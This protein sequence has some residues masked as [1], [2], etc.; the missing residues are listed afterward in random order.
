[1]VWKR[2]ITALVLVLP[3]SLT[4]VAQNLS[5]AGKELDRRLER[6]RELYHNDMYIA[7]REEIGNILTQYPVS[8][9]VESELATC[10]II[11][12]IRLASPNLDALMDEYGEK[13]RYAPE[14]MGVLLM[15][16]GYY[17]DRGDYT[18][19]QK[20]LDEVEYPLLSRNDKTVYLFERSYCQLR[21]GR[22]AEARN[23]FDRIL[24][25]R[26]N[27]YTVASTYYRGYIAYVEKDFRKAVKLLSSI[28]H[29]GHFGRILRILHPGIQ[30]HAGGLRLCGR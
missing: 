14:Y 1:M 24:D 6:V 3:L 5:P 10:A 26:Q 22:L 13:Y 11:C 7:A 23:G 19:A 21:T 4:A 2:L 29:D 25:G 12:N 18:Q 28:R 15:Y 20:I 8:P 17:F 9:A 30:S 16:A 27:R